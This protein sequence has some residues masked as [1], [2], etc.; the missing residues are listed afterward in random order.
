[1]IPAAHGRA[2]RHRT[3]FALHALYGVTLCTSAVVI[4]AASSAIQTGVRGVYG[5][6]GLFRALQIS[7]VIAVVGSLVVFLR[8]VWFG[9][10][11][12]RRL[13]AGL[14][15]VRRA[16]RA[17]VDCLPTWFLLGEI[18]VAAAGLRI[19]LDRAATLPRVF[20]D[21]LIYVSL[22]KAFASSGELAVRG[23]PTLDYSLLYPIMISPAYWLLDDGFAAFETVKIMNAA[24]IS[25]VAVPSYLLA[26][27]LV[28][29]GWALGCATLAALTPATAYSA[30]VMTESLFY[31]LFVF[32]VYALVS[33]LERPTTAR[34]LAAV[35]VLVTLF[36]VRQQAVALALAVVAAVLLAGLARR[37]VRRTVRVFLPTFAAFVVLA[38][39]ATVLSFALNTSSGSLGAHSVLVRAYEPG[40][41][42][43]WSA[44]HIAVIALSSGVIALCAFVVVTGRL[45]SRSSSERELAF[46]AASL[47]TVWWTLMSVALLSASPWGLVRLHERN[48]FFI[49]PLLLVALAYWI[50]AGLP[51]PRLLAV[52]A[53][54]IVIVSPFFLSGE[55]VHFQTLDAPTLLPW[56]E[57]WLEL[58]LESVPLVRVIAAV[59]A[60]GALAF[61]AARTRLVPILSVVLAFLVVSSALDWES[62]VDR[63]SAQELA[64]VDAAIPA[65]ES[66][67][68]INVNVPVDRCRRF[69]SPPSRRRLAVLTEFFNKSVDRVGYVYEP[70]GVDY[71]GYATPLRVRDDGTIVEG[72]TPLAT[73]YVVVPSPTRLEG[74][75][76][77]TINGRSVLGQRG[78]LTLWMTPGY[79]RLK[80]AQ[81]RGSPTLPC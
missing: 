44:R 34:Q 11:P 22:A 35:G 66:A 23:T 60:V 51:R 30:L 41:V 38:A 62:P 73:R 17:G 47:A 27:K 1:M 25:V 59:A 58:D 48:L 69:T 4:L 39:G 71:L 15:V 56:N 52:S 13:S 37:S 36:A 29:R 54:I 31:P 8:P 7:G 61:L 50:E 3:T 43:V 42:A 33:A 55:L 79:V 65:G 68:V 70:L 57:M 12:A 80:P 78:S 76:I 6:L 2:P 45:L 64:W 40:D 49:T 10:E 21:E 81:H 75:P 74:T 20:G 5:Q 14:R 77:S 9:T 16:F 46:A 19:A 32:F 63:S 24:V 26:R 28:G 53:S 67:S 72:T 18:V